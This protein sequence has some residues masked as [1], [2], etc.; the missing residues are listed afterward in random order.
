MPPS[1]FSPDTTWTGT[2]ILLSEQHCAQCGGLVN[3][4]V[5]VLSGF[6]ELG[7]ALY[8]DLLDTGNDGLIASLA[9]AVSGG[10]V[11]LLPFSNVTGSLNGGAVVG[12]G[13]GMVNQIGCFDRLWLWLW[14]SAAFFLSNFGRV[15][16]LA[17]CA[18][19]AAFLWLGFFLL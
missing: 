15:A 18:E 5:S 1:F 2:Q 12:V 9:G 4:K 11:G 19:C 3:L 7:L 17:H 13:V 16:F 8:G 6:V 14:F 10:G